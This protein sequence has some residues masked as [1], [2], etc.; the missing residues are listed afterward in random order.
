MLHSNVIIVGGGPA[1]SSCGWSLQQQGYDCLILDKQSFPRTKLCAGWIT[2]QVLQEL[3]ISAHAPPFDLSQFQTMRVHVFR[4]AFTIST[5]Q[6][7]IR[8]SEFDHWL[9]HRSGVPVHTHDVKEIRQEGN[10]YVL[11][12]RYSCQYLVGAGGT[13]C[14]VYRTFFKQRHPRS[15]ESFVVTLEEEF[16][17]KYHDGECHLWFFQNRFPGYS[18]YV[19]KKGG[20]VNVGIGGFVKKLKA[21]HDTI[22]HHWQL[23]VEELE[24][25]GL[26]TDYRFNPGG[27]VYYTRGKDDVVQDGRVLI[28]GDAA[29]LATRDLGEGIGPAVTSGLLAAESVVKGQPFSVKTVK[30]YSLPFYRVLLKF[31]GYL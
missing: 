12:G 13:S 6:Y 15:R 22:Q 26:V 16:P 2:P 31:Q 20:I 14:P 8:R 27:Y 7:A 30:K 10:R 21:N 25:D 29:G 4:K 17:Y 28:I 24:R 1:G 5:N 18:W 11:D 23:F 19:P 3:E 9:L